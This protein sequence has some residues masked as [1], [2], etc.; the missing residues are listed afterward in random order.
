MLLD[1]NKPFLE[2]Q[3]SHENTQHV[4]AHG[5]SFSLCSQ[6]NVC[7]LL[8]GTAYNQGRSVSHSPLV[9]HDIRHLQ[10]PK[11]PYM[12]CSRCKSVPGPASMRRGT[13]M[14]CKSC[15]SQLAGTFPAE[16]AIHFP[17][18]K[19]LDKPHVWVFPAL[20]VCLNCGHT[21]F[22]IPEHTL[23]LLKRDAAG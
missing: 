4:R 21:E 17:G 7:C 15:G 19:G 23:R 11:P 10:N 3:P 13:S 18:L 12:V 2:V 20:V 16:I 8:P 14:Y 5:P 1:T 22:P 6:M 9:S